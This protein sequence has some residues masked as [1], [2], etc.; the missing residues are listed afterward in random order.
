MILA[1]TMNPAIDKVYSVNDYKI[2][3][4]FR[5]DSMTAT[6]GGKG[7]NVARVSSILGEKVMATGL[8]G[9]STGAFIDREVREQGIDSRFVSINGESRICIAVMD[10]KNNTS[11]EVLEP[12]PT[13]SEKDC[14]LFLE[15]YDRL[16]DS[17]NIV[18]ASGSL[19]VGVPE[20][21]YYTLIHMAKNKGKRFILDTSGISFKRGILG[22]PFMIKP[23]Q[24]EIEK[25]LNKGLDSMS[26]KVRALLEFKEQGIELPCMTLGKNGAIAVLDKE[27]YHFYGPPIDVVN[28][29]GSGDSFI[30]GCAV[31]LAR[32]L[33]KID[34]I[35]M[36]IAC[37]MANTQFF[38]T[39][40][41][42]IELVNKFLNVIKYESM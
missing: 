28:T 29:I 20:D 27:V 41:V 3:G 34:V 7:L 5:P 15:H 26:D 42:S 40:I 39:G 2:G 23:N 35:K 17:C 1:I 13:V 36:G 25:V 12:G 6:A 18:T 30:A 14:S 8:I 24:E 38:K 22:L 4:V 32:G 11:T 9:G 37:G 10:R 33:D 31:S 16:L 19:P 21:F